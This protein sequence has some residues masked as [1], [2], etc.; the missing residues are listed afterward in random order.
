M[1]TIIEFKNL[2]KKLDCRIRVS[3]KT[4]LSKYPE[5]IAVEDAE[6]EFFEDLDKWLY[7]NFYYVE[8]NVEKQDD[9]YLIW[10]N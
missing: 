9:N 1:S 4:I 6:K 10:I 2:E 3:E 7:Y 8:K 5:G